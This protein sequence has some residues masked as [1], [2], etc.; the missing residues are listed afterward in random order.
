MSINYIVYKSKQYEEFN[1]LIL[2]IFNTQ[3]MLDQMD[4][5]WNCFINE[6]FI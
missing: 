6:M 4:S 5:F 1:D 3:S 2:Q